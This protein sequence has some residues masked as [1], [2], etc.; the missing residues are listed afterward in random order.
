MIRRKTRN[1]ESPKKSRSRGIKSSSSPTRKSRTK[2]GKGE[3][4]KKKVVGD[5]KVGSGEGG[6]DDDDDDDYIPTK[7]YDF[8]HFAKD[9]MDELW[10]RLAIITMHFQPT[11]TWYSSLFEPKKEKQ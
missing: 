9:E 2:K 6:D 4:E 11:T 5:G 10:Y 8:R 3:D 7:E 1:V